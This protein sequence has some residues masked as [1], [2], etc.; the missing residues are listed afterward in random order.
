MKRE[1]T[2]YYKYT[3]QREGGFFSSKI[4]TKTPYAYKYHLEGK[5]LVYGSI[6][7]IIYTLLDFFIFKSIIPGC[8]YFCGFENIFGAAFSLFYLVVGIS[9]IRKHRKK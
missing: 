5:G 2:E 4:S 1:P 6:I 9:L 3:I 8:T 7:G